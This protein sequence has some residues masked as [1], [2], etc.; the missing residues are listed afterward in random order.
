[1]DISDAI[2]TEIL[3][4]LRDKFQWGTQELWDL[5]EDIRSYTSHVSPGHE[6]NVISADSAD[7]RILEC[8]VAARS[9]FIVSGD[10]RHLLPLGR[11][12]G[13]SILKVAN[14]LEWLDWA[15]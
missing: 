13:I 15:P 7:N 6:L 3:R 1:L 11:Y 9:E 12:A 2:L 14:F 10:T 8:A 4:V 5:E